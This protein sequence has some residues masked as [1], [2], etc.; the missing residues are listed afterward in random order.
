M[1]GTTAFID[2]ETRSAESVRDVGGW[3]YSRHPSTQLLCM[4]FFV[5][6]MTDV[7]LWHRAHP[8]VGIEESPPPLQ[9]FEH[10]EGGGLVEAH[11]AFF[12]RVVWENVAH[13]RMGW[14][15]LPS[16][17]LRCSAS[18]ASMSSLP[19]ALGDAVRALGLE[20]RKDGDGKKAMLKVSRPRKRRKGEPESDELLWNEDPDDLQTTWEYCRQDVR[21]EMG[22]SAAIPQ[23]SERELRLWLLDQEMN[24]RGVMFDRDMA[25]RA[26]DLAARAKSEMNAELYSMTGIESATKRAAVK[27]WLEENEQLVMADTTK[28]SIDFALS[29]QHISGRARRVLDILRSVNRTSTRKYQAVL[30]RTDP[31]D[32]RARD[33][34]MYHGASTGRWS[35]KGIQVQNFPRGNVKDMDAACEDIM[36][37]DLAWVEAM[38]GDV[39]DF[40][41]G[42]LRGLV[43][44]PPGR[45]LMVADYS[46]IEARCVLWLAEAMEAL[47]VFRTGGDIYCDMATGIYG[48]K[49]SKKEHPGERQFGKQAILGLGYGMGFLTF[50]L[51]CRKYG[52]YFSMEQCRGILGSSMVQYV[53]RMRD[54][55]FPR[56]TGEPSD[57]MRSMQAL[58]VRTRL[59]EARQDPEGV[60]VELALMKYVVDVYRRRYPRVKAMWTEQETAAVEAV[61]NPGA[62]TRAGRIAWKVHGRFLCCK[63]PSGRLLRY[64]DPSLVMVKTQWGE[65]KPALRYMSVGATT[66]WERTYTYGGKLTENIT[67]AVARDIMAE[68]IVR[69]KDGGHPYDVLMTVHDELVS[70]VDEGIGS[71]KEF[72]NIVSELPSWAIGCPIDAEAA[73]YDRRYRK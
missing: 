9:L 8:L 27:K 59:L 57:R 4:G 20:E 11:N 31:C 17:Q 56:P 30:D 71:V 44:A 26:L 18:R 72:E 35:G 40:L 25:A 41:S 19:R 37:G 49:V 2:F 62:V 68:A 34:L 10:I 13:K 5:P 48:Y 6:G 28:D 33:L 23:L 55:L 47:D 36:S 45:N 66:K 32:G 1:S 54:H 12:E 29:S 50:F 67:Q 53:D 46:A 42:A 69:I 63:L 52:I 14:P 15:R 21:A 16:I 60:L 22:L 73:R 39:M 43:V 70:E 61:R 64:C 51:T 24:Y 7:G 38:R 3:L 65:A 58:K